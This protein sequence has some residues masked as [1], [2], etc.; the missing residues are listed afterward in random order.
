MPGGMPRRL[1]TVLLV[2]DEPDI[3]RIGELTLRAVGKLKVLLAASGQEAIEVVR[4][5]RPDVVLLDVMMPGLD[6]PA[7]LAQL[8]ALDEGKDLPVIFV[9]AK[10]QAAEVARYRALGATGVV[11]KP[12]DPIALPGR[13]REILDEADRDAG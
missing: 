12:F 3:R 6:G 10:I 7:T 5:E 9:T 1:E 11:A 13:I 8:R 4:R 2:D